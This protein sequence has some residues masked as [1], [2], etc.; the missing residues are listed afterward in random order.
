MKERDS[1]F[2][3]FKQSHILL[4][5]ISVIVFVQVQYFKEH[6]KNNISQILTSDK[7]PTVHLCNLH[8]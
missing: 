6:Y 1:Q 4:F 5:R 8:R 2:M 3:S 7:T